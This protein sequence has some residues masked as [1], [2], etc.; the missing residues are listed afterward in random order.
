MGGGVQTARRGVI[1][2]CRLRNAKTGKFCHCYILDIYLA[3]RDTNN[4]PIAKKGNVVPE[5]QRQPQQPPATTTMRKF[6]DE[7]RLHLALLQSVII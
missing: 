4:V 2:V 6:R 3:P 7:S 5:H 1:F